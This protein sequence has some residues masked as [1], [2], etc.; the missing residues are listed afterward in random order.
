MGDG[1]EEGGVIGDGVIVMIGERVGTCMIVGL[2]FGGKMR[3]SPGAASVAIM[4]IAV[5]AKQTFWLL[6][7]VRRPNNRRISVA[8][9]TKALTVIVSLP[10]CYLGLSHLL[11][12]LACVNKIF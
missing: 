12:L 2:S 4:P 5:N 8:L 11:T 6:S 10:S 1:V 9:I 7:S 3:L